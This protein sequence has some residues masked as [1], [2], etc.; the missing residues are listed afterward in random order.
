MHQILY[1]AVIGC[2]DGAGDAAAAS[3]A[4]ASHFR[5]GRRKLRESDDDSGHRE[6]TVDFREK[7][8]EEEQVK[9]FFCIIWQFSF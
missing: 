4:Y 9:S 7:E 2:G 6:F 1:T 5:S 3:L 8:E